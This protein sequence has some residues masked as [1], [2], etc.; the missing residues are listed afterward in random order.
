MIIFNYVKWCVILLTCIFLWY[1][2]PA[3]ITFL[4]WSAQ[5]PAVQGGFV[6]FI[7]GCFL[8]LSIGYNMGLRLRRDQ[9]RDRADA[10]YERDKRSIR[11]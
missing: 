6:G 11:K 5:W 8:P 10:E 3:V 2:W 4:A 9:A 7:V 1:V